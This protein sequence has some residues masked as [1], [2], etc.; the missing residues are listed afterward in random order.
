MKKRY[1]VVLAVLVAILVFIGLVIAS[2]FA[3]LIFFISSNNDLD[4]ITEPSKSFFDMFPVERP[5]SVVG[6]R[7][8]C[9]HGDFQG[10]ASWNCQTA[11]YG[12]CTYTETFGQALPTVV[13]CQR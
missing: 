11:L 6:N 1:I 9:M 2:D 3:L 12:T 13:K 4:G 10:G 7:A 8:M 5:F